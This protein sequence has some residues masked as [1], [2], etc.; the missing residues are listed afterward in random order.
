VC[1]VLTLVS[2]ESTVITFAP[3]SWWW[4]HEEG[5]G[6]LRGL[7]RR[8]SLKSRINRIGSLGIRIIYDDAR[9]LISLFEEMND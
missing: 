3:D 9:E 5:I 1:W 4:L 7:L 8:N 6:W 2:V